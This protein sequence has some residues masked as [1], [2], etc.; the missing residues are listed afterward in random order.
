MNCLCSSALVSEKYLNLKFLPMIGFLILQ[1]SK[2]WILISKNFTTCW[3]LAKRFLLPQNWVYMDL[4]FTI[5]NYQEKKTRDIKTMAMDNKGGVLSLTLK[6]AWMLLKAHF[7]NFSLPH[8]NH[9]QRSQ[10]SL[11]EYDIN[12]LKKKLSS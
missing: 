10:K 12:N 5:P 6:K 9:F 4:L 7:S 8:V 1:I 3:F 2:I 11:V